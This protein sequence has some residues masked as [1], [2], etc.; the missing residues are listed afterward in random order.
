MTRPAV[1]ALSTALAAAAI[2]AAT[3]FPAAAQAAA[4]AQPAAAYPPV[5]PSTAPATAP[6]PPPADVDAARAIDQLRA[7]L[8]AAFNRQDVDGLLALLAPDVVVTWQNAEVC[9]GPGEVRAYYDRMMR[10]DRP[11]VAKVSADPVVDGRQLYG[12]W[13]L[14]YGHMR[15]HFVLT[16]GTDLP[17]DSRFTATVARRGDRWLVTGFHLSVDAFDNP[18]MNY[19]VRKGATYGAAGGAAAGAAVGAGGDGFGHA[20]ST[21]AAAGDGGGVGVNTAGAAAAGVGAAAAATSR[22]SAQDAT[23]SPVRPTSRTTATWRIYRRTSCNGSPAGTASSWPPRSCTTG[24]CGRRRTS[25]SST[26]S[27]PGGPRASRPPPAATTRATTCWSPSCPGRSGGTT[28]TAGPTAAG[29]SRP[30]PP[31]GCGASGCRC[32]ASGRR[33]RTPRRCS[34]GSPP[35]GGPGRSCWSA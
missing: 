30:P 25:R 19:A 12:D 10:A 14:S 34:T 27:P 17:F 22:L 28:P 21:Q 26:P 6:T 7:G 35:G 3:A 2:T 23:C 33:P 8:I 18:V 13:A 4:A 9:R 31:S 16:D 1:V 20:P 29:C 11:V 15:D 24:S 32:R 5:A